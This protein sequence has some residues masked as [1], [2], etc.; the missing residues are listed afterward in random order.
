MI[1]LFQKRFAPPAGVNYLC[2]YNKACTTDSECNC[3]IQFLKC[4]MV[5]EGDHRCIVVNN[6]EIVGKPSDEK[7]AMTEPTIPAKKPFKKLNKRI[8]NNALP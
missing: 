4:K 6:S 2:P 1:F 8:Q 5:K 3:E 7:F